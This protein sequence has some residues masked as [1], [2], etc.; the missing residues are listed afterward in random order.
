MKKTLNIGA[1]KRTFK[2]YPTNNYECIN[3]DQRDLE[4]IDVVCDVTKLPFEDEEFDFIV[5]S[6]IVEHFPISET[7][8]VLKEWVRVLKK[9]CVIE[10]RL[11]NLHAICKKYF[12]EGGDARNIS[13]LLYGGQDYPGNFHYVGF[14]K[15]FFNEECVKVGL[16]MISYG[17]EGN[18]MIILMRRPG[19]GE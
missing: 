8:S 9:G 4:N 17:E 2:N 3:V 5:A 16:S 18:N 13:W 14:D 12:M 6:D 10:F 1:G 11:P 19:E 15:K 7:Q